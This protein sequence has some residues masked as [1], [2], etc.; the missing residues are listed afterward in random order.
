MAELEVKLY[1]LGDL[2]TNCYI[3]SNKETKEAIV[4]DPADNA[5]FIYRSLTDAGLACVGIF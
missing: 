1:Q 2:G 3:V 5:D 4:V